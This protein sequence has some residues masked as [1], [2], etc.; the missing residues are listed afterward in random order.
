WRS[1]TGASRRGAG[2]AAACDE[3]YETVDAGLVRVVHDAPR[4]VDVRRP[5]LGDS[6]RSRR[7]GGV[8]DDR[9]AAKC[10]AHG[11]AL[12]IAAHHPPHLPTLALHLVAQSPADEAIRAGDRR[13]AHR[14]T[15]NARSCTSSPRARRTSRLLARFPTRWRWRRS[16][17]DDCA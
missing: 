14:G 8:D 3:K 11:A 4:E 7:A 16:G 13:D 9:R 6:R 15:L 12:E 5:Q 2:P 17:A 10:V 1:V